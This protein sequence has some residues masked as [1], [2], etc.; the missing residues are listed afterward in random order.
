MPDPVLAPVRPEFRALA[1]A[2]V[3]DAATLSPAEWDE[4]ETIVERALESRPPGHRQRIVR[5]VRLLGA[6]PLL[7]HGRRFPALDAEAR[8]RFLERI[9]RAP[10]LSLRAG[11]REL[12]TLVFLGYYGLAAAAARLGYRADPRGWEAR[13]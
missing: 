9:E 4:L 6:A 10:L 3:P 13:R 12:R 7:R 8:A 2:I 1:T 11:F 5:L